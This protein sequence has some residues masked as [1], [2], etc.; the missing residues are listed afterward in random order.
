MYNYTLLDSER[1]NY[2]EIG[3]EG[4]LPSGE[5]I[6]VALGDKDIVIFNLSGTYYAIGD[7]CSHDDG[8]LGDGELT[9]TEVACPRHGARFVRRCE[10]RSY[11]PLQG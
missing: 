5:R 11:R 3:A 8:P 2:I 1:Y 7:I 4:E 6:F 9:G 10:W